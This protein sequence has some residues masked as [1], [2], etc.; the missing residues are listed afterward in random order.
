MTPR[1][2][3][4]AGSLRRESFNKKIVAIAAKAARNAVTEVTGVVG[5]KC[6]GPTRPKSIRSSD[7][8][9]RSHRRAQRS[10]FKN[11]A[12]SLLR[13]QCFLVRGA[14][15]L[16]GFRVESGPASAVTRG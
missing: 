6:F 11:E 1:I 4:F 15:P 14:V 3:A 5:G 10:L 9:S 8:P 13:G 7:T 16:S 12:R 2:L